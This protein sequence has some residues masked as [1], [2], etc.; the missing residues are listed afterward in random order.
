MTKEVVSDQWT[1]QISQ[2]IRSMNKTKSDPKYYGVH[3][4]TYVEDQGTTHISILAS[5]GDAVS[6]TSTINTYFGS[7][8]ELSCNIQNKFRYCIVEIIF[9]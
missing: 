8:E 7:G 5:N 6:V 3:E 1:K 2:K 9:S 4:S